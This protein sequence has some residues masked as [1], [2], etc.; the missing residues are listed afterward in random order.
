MGVA[1]HMGE[2]T[3]VGG[4]ETGAGIKL[5]YVLCSDDMYVFCDSHYKGIVPSD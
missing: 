2:A 5:Y 3:G 4:L 1:P